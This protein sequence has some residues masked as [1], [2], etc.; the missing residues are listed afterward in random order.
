MLGSVAKH[1]RRIDLDR[2]GAF[3]SGACAIHCL[4]SGLALGVLSVVGLG[5]LASGTSEIIFITVTLTVGSSA[6]YFGFRKHRSWAPAALYAVGLSAL[7]SSHL[8]LRHDSLL[9]TVVSVLAGLCFVSFHL[10]NQSCCRKLA[11]R[12]PRHDEF[13][14][15]V[16]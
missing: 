11:V 8:V 3:A 1:G 6:V 12:R 10:V 14:K 9:G 15:A 5:F 13:Q 2:M 7:V 4:L 16:W